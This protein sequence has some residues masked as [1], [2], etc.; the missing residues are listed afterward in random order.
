MNVTR[1]ENR[2]VNAL[3]SIAALAVVLSHLRTLT[4][5]DYD[6]IPHTVANHVFYGATALGHQAVVVFFVLSGYWVG[7][8]TLRQFACGRFAWRDYAVARL[9]RLWI[10]L[11]PA[12]VLTAVLDGAGHHWFGEASTYQGAAAYGGVVMTRPPGDDPLGFLL[13]AL[14]LQHIRGNPVYG[15]NSALWSLSYEFWCYL[16]F[17]LVIASASRRGRIRVGLG[18][19]AV[20]LMT[21]LGPEMEAYFPI[22]C[23]GALVAWMQPSL[24]S[25][26]DQLNPVGLLTVRVASS[27]ACAVCAVAVR[28]G[29]TLPTVLGDYIVAVAATLMMIALL[30]GGQAGSPIYHLSWLAHRS[31]SLYAIHTPLAIFAVSLLGI[32]VGNRWSPDV[33]HVTLFITLMLLLQVAALL[34]AEV[35]E[36]HTETLRRWVSGKL[37]LVA[38]ISGNGV[39][40]GWST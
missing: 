27:G 28:G 6:E 29:N 12:L 13:N 20:A 4:F 38:G 34:F 24:L 30:P 9:V 5:M 14:F 17:P 36:M 37:G 10:V 25:R 32:Q 19:T 2:H 15:T 35:T 33:A 11:V 3:R 39:R 31:Y 23:L 1:R 21:V 22:W 16:L 7:G 18:V 26:L 8:S 40:R